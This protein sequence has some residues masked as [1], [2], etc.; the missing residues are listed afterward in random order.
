M[1]T[2][3]LANIKKQHDEDDSNKG[4]GGGG[5]SSKE[6]TEKVNRLMH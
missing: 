2:E 4:Q 6:L 3:E 5:A 1:S